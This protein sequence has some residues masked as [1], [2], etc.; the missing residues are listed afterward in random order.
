MFHWEFDLL[1][2][3]M[4]EMWDE[5]DAFVVT[6]SRYDHRGKPRE[7]QLLGTDRFDWAAEKLIVNVSDRPLKRTSTWDWEQHQRRESVLAALRMF[8]LA[9]D[10]LIVVSDV[11]EI[12][13][14]SA[15]RQAQEARGAI[16]TLQM[17]MF[18]YYLNLYVCPWFYAR[19]FRVGALADPNEIRMTDPRTTTVIE[20]AGWHFSYLGT[21]EEVAYKISTFAHDEF[22]H[23][24]NLERITTS[25]RDRTDVFGRT[26]GD[27]FG[28]LMP[29]TQ[30]PLR[31]WSAGPWLP[32]HVLANMSAYERCLIAE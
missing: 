21:P 14:A 1:D 9:D 28:P 16:V 29:H 5:V 3:R 11:D 23:R 30:N 18:Y 15:L 32:D 22:D 27:E 13:R 31:V 10:D 2:L 25:M 12:I 4:R 8:D 20:N 17:P 26:Y 19:A 6:E 7:R 24:V